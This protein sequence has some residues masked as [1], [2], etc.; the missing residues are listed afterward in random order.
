MR[1]QKNVYYSVFATCS[2]YFT[3]LTQLGLLFSRQVMLVFTITA[4]MLAGCGLV[5][6]PIRRQTMEQMPVE[7]KTAAKFT[8]A[9]RVTATLEAAAVVRATSV[10]P[11]PVGRRFR[12]YGNPSVSNPRWRKRQPAATTTQARSHLRYCLR[13]LLLVCLLASVRLPFR[14]RSSVHSRP[15]PQTNLL[16]L[17]ADR[18]VQQVRPR[19]RSNQNTNESRRTDGR[20]TTQFHRPLCQVW[21]S[22]LDRQW[23]LVHCPEEQC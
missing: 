18:M 12:Y 23:T 7:M 1:H 9:A 11:V 13:L 20:V 22:R 10:R 2:L 8:T 5:V 3:S 17:D 4:A 6:T 14:Q 21:H 16:P 19:F 15:R